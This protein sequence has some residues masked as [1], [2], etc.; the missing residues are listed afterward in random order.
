M[1][2][3]DR[4]RAIARILKAVCLDLACQATKFHGSAYNDGKRDAY[5][6]IAIR[7]A[8]IVADLEREGK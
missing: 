8:D 7:L 2:K 3:N 6:S 1:G 4:A 5:L